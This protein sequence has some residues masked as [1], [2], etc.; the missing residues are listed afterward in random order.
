MVKGFGKI[1]KDKMIVNIFLFNY[2]ITVSKQRW[3]GAIYY[4]QE[5]TV[6][7][8]KESNNFIIANTKFT[9]K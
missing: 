5:V 8:T 3:C 7:A 9:P 6:I 1:I 2:K 4:L